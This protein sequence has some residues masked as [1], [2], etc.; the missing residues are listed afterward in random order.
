MNVQLES[1]YDA[2]VASSDD[3]FSSP[4]KAPLPH[5]AFRPAKR[6]AYPYSSGQQRFGLWHKSVVGMFWLCKSNQED[7]DH[8]N[9]SAEIHM[10]NAS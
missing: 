5:Q 8:E 2:G 9:S 6:R 3:C 10:Q 1:E 7:Q 4:E